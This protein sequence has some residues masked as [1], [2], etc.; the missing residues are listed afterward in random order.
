MWHWLR[1]FCRKMTNI[2]EIKRLFRSRDRPNISSFFTFWINVPGRK[3]QGQRS[4]F[5]TFFS[6][7]LFINL[8][9]IK[10]T[11]DI[12]PFYYVNKVTVI[13]QRNCIQLFYYWRS[14][15]RLYFYLS[16]LGLFRRRRKFTPPTVWQSFSLQS[17]P[18]RKNKNKSA[19]RLN[20]CK[21]YQRKLCCSILLSS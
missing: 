19:F 3:L 12:R 10:D 6:I 1:D 17:F 2:W 11:Q 4:F 5:K 9:E 13:M 18:I 15:R 21:N 14:S 16:F 8:H 20:H 7:W